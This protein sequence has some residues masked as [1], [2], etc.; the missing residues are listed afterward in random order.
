[1]VAL[2]QN[3]KNT[4]TSSD[5]FV[6]GTL[7]AC[8][9]TLQDHVNDPRQTPQGKRQISKGWRYR[10]WWNKANLA[11]FDDLGAFYPSAC[12]VNTKNAST[13]PISMPTTALPSL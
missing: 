12:I 2:H 6:S 7:G 8:C 5:V 3:H 10:W 11:P 13:C 4:C 1:M 9:Q